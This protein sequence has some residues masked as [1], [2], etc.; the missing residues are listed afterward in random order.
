LPG[1]PGI[2]NLPIGAVM[3]CSG[4]D[5]RLPGQKPLLPRGGD[6]SVLEGK[7][8]P[9]SRHRGGEWGGADRRKSSTAPIGRLAVPGA[10]SFP[11]VLEKN[12]LFFGSELVIWG[13]HI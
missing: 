4:P 2:A 5:E 7:V 11:E 8:R 3:R 1:F 13:R 10:V 9:G 12:L 6:D